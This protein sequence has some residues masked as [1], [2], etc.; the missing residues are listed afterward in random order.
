LRNG[1]APFYAW[2]KINSSFWPQLVA[3]QGLGQFARHGGLAGA[4]SAVYL[5][6][7]VGFFYAATN[8][9]NN[10]VMGE[11][12][13][14]L[15]DY[16][17]RRWH[18][19]TGVR[20]E[21]GRYITLTDPTALDDFLVTIGLDGATPELRQLIQGQLTWP[22]YLERRGEDMATGPLR[23]VITR[24][25]PEVTLPA[26]LLGKNLFPDPFNP[27]DIPAHDFVPNAL[28]Q[29]G[30]PLALSEAAR[31][32][33]HGDPQGAVEALRPRVGGLLPGVVG[34]AATKPLEQPELLTEATRATMA[35]ERYLRD[36][37]ARESNILAGISMPNATQ[38]EREA[39]VRL[40]ETLIEQGYLKLERRLQREGTLFER[41]SK[42]R[43]QVT[44]SSTPATIP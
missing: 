38:A 14:S 10:L 24:F 15:P 25:G 16:L 31:A 23:A 42:P 2:L 19:N 18:F 43:N 41:I 12:E 29:V 26:A 33:W 39:E 27:R 8:A 6:S 5:A 28:Q 1:L 22:E 11:Q 17:R 36:L 44:P 37:E 40:L 9:W 34:V 20:D 3:R 4:R 35:L 13:D 32:A 30:V 21:E 7:R